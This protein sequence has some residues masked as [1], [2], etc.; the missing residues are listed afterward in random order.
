M[1][2]VLTL[3][4]FINHVDENFAVQMID[5]RPM[6]LRLA[7]VT[8]LTDYGYTCLNRPPFSLLFDGPGP[9]VLSQGIYRLS[10][11]KMGEV[12]IGLV[13]IAQHASGF[14][15]QAVFN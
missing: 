3:E 12:E 5:G 11:P 6:V 7:L 9:D 10:H 1:E 13:P 15:Y 2:N 4:C 8:E 14:R